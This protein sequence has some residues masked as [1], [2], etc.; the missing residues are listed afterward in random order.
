MEHES[1]RVFVLVQ[2]DLASVRREH[3]LDRCEKPEADR[4]HHG[5]RG[6]VADPARAECRRKSDREKDTLRA[7]ADPTAREQPVG[8]ALVEAVLH[9]GGCEDKAAHEEEDHGIGESRESHADLYDAGDDGE[10]RPD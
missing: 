7:R 3:L 2:I 9:H 5:S 4:E 10:R 6:R 8:E 1:G